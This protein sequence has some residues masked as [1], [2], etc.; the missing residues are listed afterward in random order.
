MTQASMTIG[1]TLPQ[2][3]NAPLVVHTCDFDVERN[4]TPAD[5]I[6]VS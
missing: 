3:M 5:E 2:N 6:S 4:L 1:I